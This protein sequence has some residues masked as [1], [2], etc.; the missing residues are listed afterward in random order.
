MLYTVI[1]ILDVTKLELKIPAVLFTHITQNQSGKQG[2]DRGKRR[3]AADKQRRKTQ[4]QMRFKIFEQ[5]R[6]KK[7]YGQQQQKQRNQPKESQGLII[8]EQTDDHADYAEAVGIGIEFGFAAGRPVTVIDDYVFYLHI[9]MDGMDRHFRLDFK[10]LGQDGKGLDKQVVESPVACHDILDIG[11]EQVIDAAAHQAV[12]KIVKGA[13]VLRKISGGEPVAYDHIC[14][15]GQDPVHHFTRAV[16][17]I[18]I[19]S[20]NHK[21]APGVNFAKHPADDVSFALLVLEADNGAGLFGDFCRGIGRIII[22]H[23]NYGFGKK[24]LYIGYDLSDGLRF[25]IAGN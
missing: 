18:G 14:V 3:E 4:D 8:F 9:V 19:V 7:S 13:F 12:A 1:V 5:D 11:V 2:L 6:N 24:M 17:R 25:I 15:M 16:E 23:I 10:A 20:V 21:V 22:I